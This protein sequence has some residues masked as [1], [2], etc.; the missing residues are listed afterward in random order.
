MGRSSHIIRRQLA[1]RER[2]A[3]RRAEAERTSRAN[4]IRQALSQ[5]F[6]EYDPQA[7]QGSRFSAFEFDGGVSDKMPL[8]VKPVPSKA[9]GGGVPTP[10]SAPQLEGIRPGLFTQADIT[11]QTA[12]QHSAANPFASRSASISDLLRGYGSQ[13][14]QVGKSAYAP[15]AYNTYVKGGA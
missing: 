8:Y 9:T 3:E 10:S 2:A 6:T 4:M 5:G 15:T 1:Q 13:P 11:P 7:H 12:L 14:T